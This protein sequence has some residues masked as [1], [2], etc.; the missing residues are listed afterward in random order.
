MYKTL[1]MGA[2]I[3]ALLVFIAY[4]N[5]TPKLQEED[6]SAD[7]QVETGEEFEVTEM[8]TAPES[9]VDPSATSDSVLP[10]NAFTLTEVSQHNSETDC[11]TAVNGVV[12]DLTSFISKHPGGKR[13]I[14][15]ICGRDGTDAFEGKHG[16]Q[17][18]PAST[19]AGFEIGSLSN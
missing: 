8:A 10:D 13:G 15:S 17:P 9:E 1:L 18:R 4:Q 3:I 11:W 2:F 5:I 7:N 12:Y 14:L 6:Y 16:G 19:L